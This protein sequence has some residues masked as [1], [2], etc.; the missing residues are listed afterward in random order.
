MKKRK[1]IY[2]AGLAMTGALALTGCSKK[3]EMKVEPKIT[4]QSNP[5]DY[6]L[7]EPETKTLEPY[8]HN[9]FKKYAP[10]SVNNEKIKEQYIGYINEGSI[11]IPEGYKIIGIS[12]ICDTSENTDTEAVHI[13]FTNTETVEVKPVFNE[14]I[15]AYDY[16][17]FGTP[18]KL[19]KES[20]KTLK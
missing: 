10:V 5:L 16:S 11:S 3:T 13:W 19:E 2:L 17:D 20:E 15:N 8:Y 14:E 9:L 1:I 6:Y 4:Y 7:E 18:I 12:G